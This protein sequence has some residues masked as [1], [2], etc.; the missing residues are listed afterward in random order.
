MKANE[1]MVGDYVQ[2]NESVYKVEEISSQGWIHLLTV[3]NGTRVQMTSDYILDHIEGVTITPEILEKNGF[4]GEGYQLLILDKGD[5]LEYYH[6]E[7]RLRRYWEGIDEWENHLRVR[8]IVF[9]CHCHYVHELQ[10]ALRM[11]GVEKEIEP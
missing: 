9:M 11:C 10:H 5:W 4:V 7:H 2:L 8:D 3:E 6:H 1:L